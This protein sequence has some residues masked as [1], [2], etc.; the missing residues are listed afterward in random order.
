[1]LNGLL[2]RLA[3]TTAIL[4]CLSTPAGA[5]SIV[6]TS[7]A[8]DVESTACTLRAAVMAT[9]SQA[10]VGGCPAGSGDDTITLAPGAI[11]ILTAVGDTTDG[12]SGLP[13]ISGALTLDGNGATLMR[14]SAPDIP[15]FRVLR[16]AATGSVNVTGL[17][18]S[19]GSTH[20]GILNAGSLTL[21]NSTVSGNTGGGVSNTGTLRLVDSV[22]SHNASGGFGGGVFNGG[23]SELGSD[24]GTYAYTPGTLMVLG[25]TIS[26]NQSGA[27]GGGIANFGTATVIDSV[28]DGNVTGQGMNRA[29]YPYGGQGGSGGGIANGFGSGTPG[30]LTISRSTISNNTTGDG[31]ADTDGGGG[32]DGGGI[33][34]TYGVVIVTASTI[35]GNTTGSGGSGPD[36]GGAGGRG[37]GIANTDTVTITDSTISD[38]V[39]GNGGLNAPALGTNS[40]GPGGGIANDVLGT[41]TVVNSTIS[42]NYTGSG[43]C[44]GGFAGGGGIANAG[45]VTLASSTVSGNTAGFDRGGGIVNF[46]SGTV[47]LKN[48]IVA[49]NTADN[50]PDCC[51]SVSSEGYNL[52]ENA[53]DCALAGDMASNVIGR[54]PLLGALQDNGGPT[55]TQ[56]LLANSPA[57]DAGNPSGC[58]D[59]DG[60]VLARDQRGAPRSRPGDNRCDIGAYE[61]GASVPPEC[62][63]DCNSDGA[64]TVDELVTGVSIVLGSVPAAICPSLNDNG[65]T[66]VTVDDLVRAVG[67]ALNGCL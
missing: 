36:L 2:K 63:G 13:S 58:T 31:G 12:P 30:T 19:N 57:T 37:G 60:A 6:L 11:Y 27:G 35:R 15:I 22:V 43:G 18:V 9:N 51:G 41:V 67:Y 29:P 56:A 24:C 55:A 64:V 21:T 53:A 52:I 39:T 61:F 17:T 10:V 49:E 8:D 20:G 33:Y 32:G 40:G 16:I 45:T 5:T 54:A 65:D 25:S 44:C 42:G 14:G 3:V 23:T 47:T 7:T 46:S 62:S 59:V 4:R 50:G 1:M 66:M 38:N 48:S 34:N 28:V 26:D